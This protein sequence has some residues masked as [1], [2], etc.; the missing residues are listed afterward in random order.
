MRSAKDFS[1][2]RNWRIPSQRKNA[3]TARLV[4]KV[5]GSRVV[6]PP[7]MHQPLTLREMIE[8]PGPRLMKNAGAAKAGRRPCR[9]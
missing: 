7:R 4:R 2:R 5:R 8:S 1:I 9:D 6:S 3:V